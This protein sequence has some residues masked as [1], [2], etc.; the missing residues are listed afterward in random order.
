MR[1]QCG[2]FFF[3]C[4]CFPILLDKQET[5]G[6]CVI[7]EGN[8]LTS[9]RSCPFK[10]LVMD[11]AFDAETM[12]QCLTPTSGYSL[13]APAEESFALTIMNHTYW[14]KIHIWDYLSPLKHSCPHVHLWFHCCKCDQNTVKLRT[15]WVTSSDS[16][17]MPSM[18]SQMY[19]LFI[20]HTSLIPSLALH[21]VDHRKTARSILPRWPC[22]FMISR[23]EWPM[24]RP[25]MCRILHEN[26]IVSMSM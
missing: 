23:T 24:D 5:P 2:M 20:C 22:Q 16:A 1:L 21:A 26:P 9:L 17:R 15:A 14:P 3:F 25:M 7:N 18:M 13:P 4:F 11:V 12:K 10:L 8:V 19:D 6:K